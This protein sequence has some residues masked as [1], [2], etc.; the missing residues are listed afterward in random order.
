ML[1]I[2]QPKKI[3]FLYLLL[4]TIVGFG[5]TQKFPDVIK[6]DGGLISGTINS[7]NDIHIYKGIPFAAPPINDLRWREPQPVIAWSGIK[8]CDAFSASPMQGKPIPFGVYTKEFLIP[9]SPISEDCLYLNVWTGAKVSSEKKPVIVWIYGGGF[10]SGGSACPIYDG[11]AT[12]KK[13]IVFVSINYRVG[14]FGFFAHPELTKE[15]GRNASGN[16]GLMDQIAA[17]KWVKK[18]IAA[19]GGNPDNVTIAGQSAGSMSV[20]CLVVSPLC[21][22]LFKHAIAESGAAFINGM[23]H[24]GTLKQGEEDGLKAAQL[25]QA[26][27]IND[28]RKVSAEELLKKAK[29]G[30]MIVDGYVLPDKIANIFAAGKQNDVGVITGWNDDDAFVGAL[31]NAE[32]FKKQAKEQYGNDAEIFLKYY[33]ASTDQEAAISQVKVNRDMLMAIQNY[34][35]AN[36]QSEKGKAKIY[37]YNFNR[38]VPATADFVKYG[39][40][41]TGEVVYAYDNLKFENRPWQQTDIDLAKLM[42]S[43]WVNFATTGNPNGKGLPE[44][45]SYNTKENQ[46]MQFDE[47]S[48]AKSLPTK[49]Q[50]DFLIRRMK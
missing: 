38:K 30:G 21:K 3:I 17:L 42:S 22:G 4:I 27:S 32:D 31:K 19:F 23:I 35:W 47:K 37:V 36:T 49:D 6:V 5:Q 28:L 44:W 11:E 20:N 2:F 7:T 39:A 10:I 46:S 8:K 29:G 15:S 25:L 40:F 45:P 12:A 26:S 18:N 24:T 33:P 14:V 13:G 50:L 9:E 48:E 43:Y 16:Y 1:V 34:T 41:H